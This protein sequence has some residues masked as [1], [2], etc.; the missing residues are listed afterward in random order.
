MTPKQLGI[1]LRHRGYDT[2]ERKLRDWRDKGL[3][4]PLMCCGRGRGSGVRHY[5]KDA[6]VIDQAITVHDLLSRRAR[7][8]GALLGTWFAGYA[9]DVEKVRKAWLSSVD[10]IKKRVFRNA[11]SK[12][13][14]EDSL[15]DLSRDLAKKMA[16]VVKKMA[17]DTDLD[18]EKL[19]ALLSEILNAYFD[20][21]SPISIDDQV[22]D[23]ARKIFDRKASTLEGSEL[24]TIAG[25]EKILKFVQKNLSLDAMRRLILSATV[26]EFEVAHRRW[27]SAIRIIGLWCSAEIDRAENPAELVREGRL[28]LGVFGAPCIFA[29]LRLGKAEKGPEVDS[30]LDRIELFVRNQPNVWGLQ[31]PT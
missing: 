7:S 5:W 27:Q 22:V 3:L 25:S 24:V 12:E 8:E 30:W 18:W 19:E 2:T 4:P 20:S 23:T 17:P 11:S 10:R 9:M 16:P 1:E 29:L 15:S 13:Q 28:L 31:N 14:R 26:G 21:S 6:G